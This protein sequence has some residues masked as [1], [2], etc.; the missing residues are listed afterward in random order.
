MVYVRNQISY[1]ESLYQELIRC[2]ACGDE[3]LA[4]AH[5]ALADGKIRLK[6]WEFHFD[7]W[8]AATLLSKL[9]RVTVVVRNYHALFQQSPVLDFISVLGVDSSPFEYS[10]N[11]CINVRYSTGVSLARFYQNRVGRPLDVHEDDVVRRLCDT[12]LASL[13]T[14]GQLRN[15]LLARFSTSNEQLCEYFNLS[16][17]GLFVGEGASSDVDAVCSMQ[18]VFSF[19]TQVVIRDLSRLLAQASLSSDTHIE[20]EVLS[21]VAEWSSWVRGD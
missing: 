3:Y 18:R 6:E 21:R 8:K 1:L 15:A 20:S 16:T 19:K 11:E 2:D 13:G 7:Y 10:L 14:S 9:T 17:E 12:G 4:F 5:S